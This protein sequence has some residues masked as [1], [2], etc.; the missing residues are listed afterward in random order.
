MFYHIEG[1]LVEVGQNLAVIDCG[2]VGYALN[3]TLNTL[4]CIKPGEKTK[5][6]VSEIIKEDAFDLYGFYTKS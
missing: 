4:S 6:Y 1:N 5:L 2:G 3:V